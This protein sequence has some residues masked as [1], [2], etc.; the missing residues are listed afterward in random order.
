ME[1]CNMR[2]IAFLICGM[3]T[4]TA[5]GAVKHEMIEYKDGD[6]LLEGYMTYD[7]ASDARRPGVL[8]VHSWTGLN[9]QARK[10]ADELARLGY[11]AFALDMYGKGVYTEDPGEAA[12]RS[13]GLKGDIP[14]LRRRALAGLEVLRKFRL[15][16]PSKLAAV[17]YCFGGTTVLEIAR[18]GEPIQGVVSFHGGL[19]TPNPADAR[20]IKCKVLALH[21]AN[22]PAVPSDEV[23]VFEKEMR[24]AGVNWE[25]VAYG[26][27]VHSF[28]DP[29]ANRPPVSLYHEQSAKR[30]WARMLQFFD[31]IFR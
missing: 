24:N 14:T 1:V 9:K 23:A 18:S 7:D 10:T 15:A 20:N 13:G 12:Q 8:I 19:G 5:S 11:V 3:F 17:G 26:G 6:L 16:D 22:D 27:A 21:G 28:T 30:S 4:M 2:G 29:D 31:E 25:L